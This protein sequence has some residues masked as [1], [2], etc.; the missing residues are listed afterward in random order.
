MQLI[1]LIL[2][3]TYFGYVNWGEYDTPENIVA[4]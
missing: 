4:W 1:V 2:D 3:P